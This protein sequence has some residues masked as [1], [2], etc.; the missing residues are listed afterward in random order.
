MQI[1]VIILTYNRLKYLIKLLNSIKRNTVYPDEI[2]IGVNGNDILTYKSLIDIKD[3]RYKDLNI[4][5]FLFNTVVSRGRGRNVLVKESLGDW[6]VFLDD[7][8]ILKSEY[9][10]NLKDLIIEYSD[11]SVIG[12][13]QIR[14]KRRNYIEIAS[15][16]V[17]SSLWGSGLYRNRFRELKD[18]F[19][20]QPRDLILCNLAV[21]KSVFTDYNIKFF[22]KSITA[23]EN[24]FFNRVYKKGL[25]MLISEKINVYHFH[26]TDFINF[27]K[28]FFVYG[29][30][31]GNLFFYLR[32]FSFSFVSVFF[33][34]IFLIISFMN[35]NYFL[36]FLFLYLA[37]TAVQV[38]SFNANIKVKL[39]SFFM[40]PVIHLFYSAG[41]IYGSFEKILSKSFSISE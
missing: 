27:I 35:I 29:R 17:I 34:I 19:Y 39:I 14:G 36:I 15:Y 32:D 40:Y 38:L 30:G 26:R 7:D 4:K 22:E 31:R 9:F 23:E 18:T 37:I 10:K 28:Q 16:L 20:A 12:G 25:K 41:Y 33:I 21:K 1:S 13:G 5:L 2:I 11:V 3:T 6:I 24:Y 8:V